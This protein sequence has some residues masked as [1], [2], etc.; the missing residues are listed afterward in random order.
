MVKYPAV[1]LTLEYFEGTSQVQQPSASLGYLT[2]SLLIRGR[3]CRTVH[4]ADA[5]H[6]MR[7][8]IPQKLD[9][10]ICIQTGSLLPRHCVHRSAI[11]GGAGGGK[12]SSRSHIVGK[13]PTPSRTGEFNTLASIG[14]SVT[15]QRLHQKLINRTPTRHPQ[16]TCSTDR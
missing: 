6:P 10:H 2:L 7:D 3:V 12:Y 16:G 9:Y 13:C 4:I 8:G 15:A 14:V 11:L 5:M 1:L